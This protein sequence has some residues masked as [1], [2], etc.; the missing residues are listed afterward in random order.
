MKYIKKVQKE[1][2]F[3]HFYA[4]C[5]MATFGKGIKH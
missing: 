4:F 2:Y 1:N 3:I 5:N